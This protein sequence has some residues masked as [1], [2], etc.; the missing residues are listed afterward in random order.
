VNHSRARSRLLARA[1]LLEQVRRSGRSRAAFLQRRLPRLLIRAVITSR[2]ALDRDRPR[3]RPGPGPAP[4]RPV[5]SPPREDD[6]RRPP[7]G[8][9]AALY[10]FLFFRFCPSCS[11]YYCFPVVFSVFIRAPARTSVYLSFCRLFFPLLFSFIRSPIFFFLAL[12]VLSFPYSILPSSWLFALSFRPRSFSH[13]AFFLL[14]DFFL[15]LISLFPYFSLPFLLF[16]LLFGTSAA[17]HRGWLRKS[18]G[19]GIMSPVVSG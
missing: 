17:P 15:L 13:P 9:R 3:W 14:L 7:P 8:A 1:R 16:S 2:F 12:D 4:L 5:W 19:G 10:F 6:S 11:V 18:L